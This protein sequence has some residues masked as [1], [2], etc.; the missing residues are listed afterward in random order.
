LTQW[1]SSGSEGGQFVP[2][3]VAVDDADNVFVVDGVN[4]RVL[5]FGPASTP[6][7][8]IVFDFTP[9]TLNLASGGLWVTGFLEPAS[10]FAA[11]DIDI[12]SVRLNGT[13]PVDL[14]APT[15]LGDHDD[16]GVT[17]LMVKFNRAAVELT[18]S[19]GENVS[20]T[21]SGMV[22]G[23]AFIGTDDIRV[24]RHRERRVNEIQYRKL[25]W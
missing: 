16:D 12:S 10:P 7:I 15:T 21:V 2:T 14:A 3:G 8:T 17:D 4:A 6:P 9:S 20:V 13:V 23:H 11:S 18:V 24:L 22:D 25:R 19:E 5:K 1:G